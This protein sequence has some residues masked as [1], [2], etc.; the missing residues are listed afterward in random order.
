MLARLSCYIQL[1]FQYSASGDT[2]ETGHRFTAAAE[3]VITTLAGTQARKHVSSFIGNRGNPV[4]SS[5]FTGSLHASM[6]A[7]IH[8][9]C[10]TPARSL[11][12][13]GIAACQLVHL[14]RGEPACSLGFTG[15]VARQLVHWSSLALWQT[16]SF[17]GVPWHAQLTH[18]RSLAPW[19]T[20]SF[21]GVPWHAQLIHWR[22]LAPCRAF[23]GMLARSLTHT[24]RELFTPP[25]PGS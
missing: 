23:T 18:W 24:H 3:P 9:N 25:G 7:G 1:V 17:A 11:A 2:A 4:R 22:S 16:S 8:W 19:Q 20:S 12:F 10:G 6:L 21:A 13:T 5:A 15:T 14:H